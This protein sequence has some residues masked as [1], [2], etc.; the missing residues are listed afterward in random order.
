MDTK[1][2]SPMSFN[3]FKASVEELPSKVA[4]KLR[5]GYINRFVDT[6]SEFYK[7]Y[8]ANLELHVDGWCYQGYLWDCLRSPTVITFTDLEA[9]LI[10]ERE[11]VYVM[12]DIHSRD[13]VL[14]PNYWKFDRASVLAVRPD[15]LANNLSYLPEDLYIFDHELNW[16]LVITHEEANGGGRLCMSAVVPTD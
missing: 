1:T 14:I 15:V 4:V 12:W 3:Q 11:P 10:K 5:E 16:T 9:S 8:I 7:R 13:K 2:P 6:T